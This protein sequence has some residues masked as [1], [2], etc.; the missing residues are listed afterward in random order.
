[1]TPDEWQEIKGLVR[2]W[3]ALYQW[4]EDLRDLRVRRVGFDIAI[5]EA[6]LLS[7]LDRLQ[8]TINRHCSGR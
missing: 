1:M 6:E 4:L 2:R 3:Q 5:M 7:R 8:A